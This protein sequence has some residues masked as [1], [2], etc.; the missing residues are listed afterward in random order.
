MVFIVNLEESLNVLKSE[1]F[2][3]SRHHWCGRKVLYETSPI[4]QHRMEDYDLVSPVK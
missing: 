1:H 3:S 2:I 4:E